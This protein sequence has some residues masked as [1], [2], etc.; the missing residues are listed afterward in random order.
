[1]TTARKAPAPAHDDGPRKSAIVTVGDRK[2]AQRQREQQQMAKLMVTEEVSPETKNLVDRM[3]L[4]RWPAG[5]LPPK[6]L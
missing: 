6:K 1:M 5:A 3:M 4:G 2:A